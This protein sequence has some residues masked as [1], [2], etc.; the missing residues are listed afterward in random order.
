[1]Q[2]P[3]EV[4]SAI[5]GELAS[6]SA[7]ELAAVVAEL[8]D[9]YRT[10]IRKG[11]GK[12]LRSERDAA[13]YAAYR[14]PATF[15]AAY[16]VFNEIKE[17]L[18]DWQPKTCLDVGAG[19]GTAA[20]A[21][22]TVWP[23][24]NQMTLLEREQIMIDLGKRLLHRSASPVLR[25]AEWVKADLAGSWPAHAVDLVVASYVVNELPEESISA[26]VK[27]LWECTKGALV[28]IEPGT[29]AGFARIRQVRAHLLSRGAKTVAPCPHD[30][31]CPLPESDWCHFA[32]RVNRSRLHRQVKAGEL[33]Y[34]DEKF[35][36]VCVSRQ[37]V[38]SICGRVLRHP[39]ISKGCIQLDLCTP[40]GISRL[41]VT[42]KD[43]ERYRKARDWKWGSAVRE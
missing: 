39:Q 21:A 26:L 37:S 36:Y 33:S 23:V 4:M 8:S 24:L 19:P 14:L 28:V 1:M 5:E 38:T 12:H 7:S 40:E 15:A 2:L 25:Q 41:V 30:N 22:A 10:G 16:A 13:A 27:R 20:W 34:E 31:P 6:Y 18:P 3:A 43:K 32:Q 17:C 11:K 29:P 42:R 9:S 35:S